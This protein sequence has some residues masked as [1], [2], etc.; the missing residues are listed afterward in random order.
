[1]NV[2]ISLQEPTK[3]A[4]LQCDIC[5]EVVKIVD[6]YAEENKTEVCVRACVRACVCV[7]TV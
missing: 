3:L 7:I 4:S 1:M 6:Q 5:E 2:V